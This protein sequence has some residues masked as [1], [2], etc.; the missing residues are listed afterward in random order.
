MPET[1]LSLLRRAADHLK[2]HHISEPR[3]SAELLLG[4]VLGL[5]RLALYLNA[6]RPL[7]AEELEGFSRCLER[8]LRREPVQFITGTQE[9]WSLALTVTPDVLIPRPETELLV[10]ALL[11]FARETGAR[12]MRLMDVGTG[13]GAIAVAAARELPKAVVVAGDLSL[14]ALKLA[15]DNA[16]RHQVSERIL[17]LCMD[18]FCGLGRT[19]FDAVVTNPPY[20]KS[21]DFSLLP[22]EIRDYEPRYALDGGEDGL[23]TIRAII[24]QAPDFL[25]SGGILALEMGAGQA[26]VVGALVSRTNRY[27]GQH[28]LKDYS[29]IDRVLIAQR[30]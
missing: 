1:V 28:M 23:Q 11:D 18:L 9:F 10:E 24:D 17:F 14:A 26:E 7:E 20:V 16:R 13:S 21:S 27:R 22:R 29:A 4:H 5:D 3:A 12:Q 15:R 19:L 25:R 8:R 6:E 30:R 2:N